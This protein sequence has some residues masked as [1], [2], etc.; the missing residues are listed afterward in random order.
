MLDIMHF[1]ITT[2]SIIL[3]TE[4][5]LSNQ[6]HTDELKTNFSEAYSIIITII[7]N[8]DGADGGSATRLRVHYSNVKEASNFTKSLNLYSM[9]CLPMF[10]L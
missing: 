3:L 10:W 4:I 7:I 8:T 2:E 6:Q 9:K 1:F 5:F